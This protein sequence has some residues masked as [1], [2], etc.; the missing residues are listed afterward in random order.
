MKYKYPELATTTPSGDNSSPAIKSHVD[1]YLYD[2]YFP[3]GTTGEPK[4]GQIRNTMKILY[5][6]VDTSG[7][8]ILPNADSMSELSIPGDKSRSY[9]ML[10][11]VRKCFLSFMRY[12]DKLEARQK[13]NKDGHSYNE[14]KPSRT[15]V[16]QASIFK[17]HIASLGTDI[18]DS[19]VASEQ[20]TGD[21][22]NYSD[23]E[24]YYIK[25]M[26]EKI[27]IGENCTL[28]EFCLSKYSSP[29]QTG[30][31]ID[32]SSEDCSDDRAKYEGFLGDENYSLFIKAANRFGFRVDRHIP[33]RLYFDLSSPYVR[34]Q[35]E[36]RYDITTLDQF[37]SAFY[38]RVHTADVMKIGER[39]LDSYGEL[40]EKSPAYMKPEKC[41]LSQ[42]TSIRV[43]ERVP[44]SMV[45]FQEDITGGHKLRLYAYFRLLERR[46]PWTQKRFDRLV[47]E[48][49]AIYTYRSEPH[50]FAHLEAAFSDRTSDLILQNDLTKQKYSDTMLSRSRRNVKF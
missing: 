17:R 5:G 40:L 11:P 20:G 29:L 47:D 41:E 44:L 34:E 28:A 8:V 30:L 50:A 7:Y 14:I 6:K 12:Y 48:A 35:L 25:K 22:E 24:A 4:A 39:I 31:V 27:S 42:G 32:L 16:D 2:L 9:K 13:I 33:W 23:Y 49:S 19:I 43:K 36:K 10:I 18:V 21:I 15:F 46:L 45:K 1:A 38:H 26:T 3:H 37:F